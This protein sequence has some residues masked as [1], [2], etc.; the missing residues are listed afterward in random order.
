MISE[1]IPEEK[2]RLYELEQQLIELEKGNTSI[3]ASEITIGLQ[4]SIIRFEEIEKLIQKEQK[5]KRD[6]YRR[7]L[8]HL[9]NTHQHISDLLQNFY[10]RHPYLYEKSQ[11]FGGKVGN[12]HQRVNLEDD[13]ALELAENGSLSR[14]SKML[15]DYLSIGK[16]TLDELVNQRERLKGIQRRAFDILNYL[17]LSNTVM[18]NVELR[19]WVDKWIVY[20]GMAVILVLMFFVWWYFRK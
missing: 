3:Q 7:R 5:Q 2:R 1:L 9:R 6:D 8:Q 11:L 19:D 17:G 16:D 18:K 13:M 4:N 14:S 10:Q 12:I 20:I 15:N